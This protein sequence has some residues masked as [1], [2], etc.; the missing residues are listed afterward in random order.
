MGLA[1]DDAHTVVNDEA[2]ADLSARVDLNAGKVS[3]QLGIEPGQE[4]EPVA[5]EPV[6]HP[7][8]EDGVNAGVKEQDLQLAPGRRVPGLIGAQGL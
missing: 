6:G 7:V 1:D 4:K 2:A 5:V 3:G 8:E